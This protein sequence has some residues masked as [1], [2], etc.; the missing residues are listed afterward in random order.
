M[1]VA[2]LELRIPGSVLPIVAACRHPRISSRGAGAESK[3]GNPVESGGVA[4]RSRFEARASNGVPR[5]TR[6]Y[7]R[8]CTTRGPPMIIVLWARC[9]APRCANR[10][11]SEMRQIVPRRSALRRFGHWLTCSPADEDSVFRPLMQ[12][13]GYDPNDTSTN[14][15]TPSGVGNVACAA[16]LDF[17]HNDESEPA[18]QA[19]RQRGTV[20]RLHGISAHKPAL[21]GSSGSCHDHRHKPLA[22]A[23]ICEFVRKLSY[24]TVRRPAVV[25]GD[26]VS[27]RSGDQFRTRLA[28]MG[29]AAY[30]SSEFRDQAEELLTLSAE[31]TDQQK[32]IAEYWADGPNSELPPGHWNLFAQFV[33][34]RDDHSVDDDV[35]LFFALTNAIF[36]AGIVAWDAKH[37]SDSARPVTTVPYL[38]QGQQ[39]QAWGGPGKGP[40]VLDGRNWVPYQLSQFPTPP[41]PEFVSGHSA[42]SAAGAEILRLFTGSDEFGDSV[43]FPAGASRIEPALTPVSPVTLHWRTFS[44][45]AQQAGFSRRLGGIHFRG[46]DLAGRKAGR[47]VARQAWRKAAGLWSGWRWPSQ[48]AAFGELLDLGWAEDN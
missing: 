32:M 25:Q 7:T 11:L 46:A 4:G 20:R 9:S 42:F 36:D 24:A 40:I 29:P 10:K 1:K 15:A 26:A 16:V 14:T 12:G 44:E 19:D 31:L 22:A 5:V 34:A 3:S 38:F 8:A 41:F 33:S 23:S 37:A 43:T 48:G 2:T 45:A 47:I 27:L 13:L 18:W 28:R 39:V 30:G 17:R 35:K 21:D 6:L